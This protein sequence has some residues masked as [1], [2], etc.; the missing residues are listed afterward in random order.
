M[1]LTKEQWKKNLS[2]FIIVIINIISTTTTTIIIV[3]QYN[4]RSLVYFLK[5]FK[6]DPS[7]IVKTW[8]LPQLSQKWCYP[9]FW[10]YLVLLLS[11]VP[12]HQQRSHFKEAHT[13]SSP[14]LLNL[15]QQINCFF[16]PTPCP[17]TLPGRRILLP[18]PT[19]YCPFSIHLNYTRYA[20]GL[21]NS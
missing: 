9:A 6:I 16:P 18:C 10:R 20:Y 3:V 5:K 13:L 21:Q 1:S 12:G 19:L 15:C 7:S 17:D 4:R 8:Q 11:S 2:N 14:Y